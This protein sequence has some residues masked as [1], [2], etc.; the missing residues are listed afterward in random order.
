MPSVHQPAPIVSA[1]RASTAP[2]YLVPFAGLFG[3]VLMISLV[4]AG[5]IVSVGGL[6][7][8]ARRP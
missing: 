7:F 4:L 5:K 6:T 2:V 3:A 1:E 8:T